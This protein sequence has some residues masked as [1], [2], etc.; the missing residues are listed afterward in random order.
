[1]NVRLEQIR[2]DGGTQ[3]RAAISAAVVAE[4]AEDMRQ[5]AEFP[6]VV[7]FFDGTEYW[8]ADGFHRVEAARQ[9]GHEEIGAEIRQGD[10]RKAVLFSVGANA[11]HGFRRTNEDK[12]RAVMTLLDDEEWRKWSDNKIASQCGVSH[13]FVGSLRSS[14]V[15]VTSDERR[16]TTKHGTE[17]VMQTANIG[18]RVDKWPQHEAPED[19]DD[20]DFFSAEIP[21]DAPAPEWRDD[22]NGQSSGDSPTERVPHVAQNSG[23]NEWYTPPEYLEAAHE[24]MG[25]IDTDPASCDLAN[26]HVRAAEYFS[27]DDDGLS[28]EWTGRVW[29]NPPYSG[30][31]IGRF[32]D[33]MVDQYRRGNVTEAIVLVNSATETAWFQTLAAQAD[34]ICFPKGRIKYLD[35][36]GKPANTPLQGQAFI[37]LG[38]QKKAFHKVF[39]A[40]GFVVNV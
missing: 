16:Y 32:I 23:N 38:P 22:R 6:R 3:P 21:E 25:G 20:A 19:T 26:K 1:M 5:G 28:Q 9:A 29:M 27:V 8:L 12:R 31:L 36:T 2:T 30:D 4:Y 13:P 34:A 18:Q 39:S 15:T 11:N 17:A 10:R 14:L 35:S 24:V 40:F 7:L 37:Y 33:R